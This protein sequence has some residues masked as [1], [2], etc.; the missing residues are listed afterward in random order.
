M[1]II[2]T[3]LFVDPKVVLTFRVLLRLEGQDL[4]KFHEFSGLYPKISFNWVWKKTWSILWLVI[5][6]TCPSW[7]FR[8]LRKSSKSSTHQPLN[9]QKNYWLSY[10]ENEIW[11]ICKPLPNLRDEPPNHW[12]MAHR[13]VRPCKVDS[14]L[15]CSCGMG[16]WMFPHCLQKRTNVLFFGRKGG[17]TFT[18]SIYWKMLVRVLIFDRFA[19]KSCICNTFNLLWTQLDTCLPLFSHH[20]FPKSPGCPRPSH[21]QNQVGGLQQFLWNTLRLIS[22]VPQQQLHA[23]SHFNADAT[24]VLKPCQTLHGFL[25]PGKKTLPH[26]VRWGVR[27][28]LVLD[29]LELEGPIKTSCW[30]LHTFSCFETNPLDDRFTKGF[31]TFPWVSSPCKP[32]LAPEGADL[33]PKAGYCGGTSSCYHQFSQTTAHVNEAATIQGSL[34][35]GGEE[36]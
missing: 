21:G 2:Q 28:V 9:H 10:S 3:L 22:T 24:I 29:L 35:K 34:L 8:I 1:Q 36:T 12:A 15:W 16:D 5:G 25:V 13:L 19:H 17:A 30:G 7:W 6:Y 32:C 26:Q 33:D 11:H 20:H 23:L 31:S 27:R 14:Q 18:R 4:E